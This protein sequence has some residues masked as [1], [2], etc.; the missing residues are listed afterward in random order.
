MKR[1]NPYRRLIW[2]VMLWLLTTII[3]MASGLAGLDGL[4]LGQEM[5]RDAVH[6]ASAAL[7]WLMAAWFFARLFRIVVVSGGRPVPRLL[8]DMVSI[9]LFTVA[10]IIMLGSVFHQPVGALVTTSGVVVAVLGFSLRELI[11][12][13]FAGISINLEHPFS[14]GDWL[15]IPPH[16][17]VGKVVEINWRSTRL[18]TLNGVTM[19]IPN[20]KM[21]GSRFMN[22]STPH[23]SFRAVVTV[24]LG[25][26]GAVERARELML[27]AVRATPE[28]LP[29]PSPDVLVDRFGDHGVHYLVRFWV[30][31]YEPMMV[32]RSRVQANI[33][34]HLRLG[35]I[36]QLHG[37]LDVTMAK[38]PPPA[39]GPMGR[40]ADIDGRRAA[41][42]HQVALFRALSGDDL[43]QLSQTLDVRP[44]KAGAVVFEAGDEGRSFFVVVEGLLEVRDDDGGVLAIL[45]AGDV[46]G[47]MSLLTGEPRSATVVATSAALLFEVADHHLRPIM[48][49]RPDL[50]EALGAIVEARQQSNR[51]QGEGG[52]GAHAGP[53][54]LP[55]LSRI[56]DF[57]GLPR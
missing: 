51:R 41:V 4:W 13:I 53:S 49:R 39:T 28:V 32:I 54:A 7:G 23:R 29:V 6:Q 14:L 36:E 31:D 5:V 38:V 25:F 17:D 52:A 33:H 16:S 8:S 12:D 45:A 55:L 56:R 22:Y 30:P 37:R 26:E 46:F 1:K 40:A 15:E 19:V 27:A 2:P 11:G 42:L 9:L 44:V 24:V 20:G 50:A 43:Q 47:E 21:A 57:F 10:T 3:A 34:K 35:G 48:Q 18:V